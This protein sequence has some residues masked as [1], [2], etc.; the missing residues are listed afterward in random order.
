MNLWDQEPIYLDEK[1]LYKQI[2]LHLKKVSDHDLVIR[3]QSSVNCL[4]LS[5][6]YKSSSSWKIP[7]L[8]YFNNSILGI[9]HRVHVN[10]TQQ[11]KQ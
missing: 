4:L 11:L 10:R 6:M 7:F 8:K 2:R 5:R 3:W 1:R 9:Q